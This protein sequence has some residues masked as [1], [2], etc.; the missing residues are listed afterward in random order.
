MERQLPLFLRSS[1]IIHSKHDT[2]GFWVFI[3]IIEI[4]DFSPTEDS[5]D[6]S[7]DPCSDSDGLP[8][9]RGSGDILQWL[10]IYRLTGESSLAE[11]PWP[12]L[13]QTG[14][15]VSW[16]PLW[17]Q[18]QSPSPVPRM[19]SLSRCRRDKTGQD[20][21]RQ[22]MMFRPF[23]KSATR[24]KKIWVRRGMGATLDVSASH[25]VST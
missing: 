7:S 17:E 11:E 22:A 9:P 21:T 2:I 5:S 12:S 10:C 3:K 13:P 15:D 23:M 18:H 14:G 20:R 1:E 25:S 16:S 19:A 6:D 4:H 24:F 8:G